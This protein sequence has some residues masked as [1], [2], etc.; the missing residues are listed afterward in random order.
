MIKIETIQRFRLG[1][2]DAFEEILEVESAGLLAYISSFVHSKDA[3]DDIFQESCLKIWTAHKQLRDPLQLR[4]WMFKIARNTVYDFLR[5][6][7]LPV[8]I[9][10]LDTELIEN[11]SDYRKSPYE[12]AVNAEWRELIRIEI[13]KMDSLTQE[14]FTLCYLNNM[15]FSEISTTLNLPRGT[16]C[17]RICRALERIRKSLKAK[18][19]NL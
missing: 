17:S 19:I 8:V 1:E 18:K 3:A 12:E 5:K 10:V 4:S 15:S 16:V 9:S 13:D 14:I 6:S 7:N 11:L 2:V